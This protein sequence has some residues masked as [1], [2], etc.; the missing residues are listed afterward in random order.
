[1]KGTQGCS[2]VDSGPDRRIAKGWARGWMAALALAGAGAVSSAPAAE[3]GH[4]Q[5]GQHR[6]AAVELARHRCPERDVISG[7]ESG[8][9]TRLGSDRA[10]HG[11]DPAQGGQTRTEVV[12]ASM[13]GILFPSRAAH[14]TRACKLAAHLCDLIA[15]HVR[16]GISR[17]GLKR[18]PA[19][20]DARPR[21]AAPRWRDTAIARAADLRTRHEAA[22]I[23]DDAASGR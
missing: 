4:D 2:R 8:A 13:A 7:P 9:Q 23:R 1:M 15:A 22:R 12:P 6:H 20:A 21:A 18:V 5:A 16:G 17:V 10:P 3:A 11:M 14:Y 19:P